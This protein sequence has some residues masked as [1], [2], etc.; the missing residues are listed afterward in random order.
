MANKQAQSRTVIKNDYEAEY[1]A[2]QAKAHTAEYAEVRRQHPAVERKLAEMVRWH[3]LR[4][5]RY[6]GR[7]K[8]RYQGLLTGLVVNMKRLVRLLFVPGGSRAGT[9]RAG[10]AVV[11]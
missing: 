8:V 7:A 1:S 9:V 5:A 4:R 3:G 10:L 6:R 2:A 11:G